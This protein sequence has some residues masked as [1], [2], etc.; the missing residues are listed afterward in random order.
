[1]QSPY[2]SELLQILPILWFKIRTIK[3][4]NDNKSEP[5]ESMKTKAQKISN[6][7]IVPKSKEKIE[8]T[9]ES[10]SDAIKVAEKNT[11]TKNFVTQFL[12]QPNSRI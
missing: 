12:G 2:F 1:M 7:A 4:I 3:T 5:M 9:T 6:R 10:V 11:P 8:K